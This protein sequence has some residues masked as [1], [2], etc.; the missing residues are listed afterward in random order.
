MRGG[1]Q[2]G[3]QHMQAHHQH[4]IVANSTLCMSL[5]R[6]GD[7]LVWQANNSSDIS[8]CLRQSP[9]IVVDS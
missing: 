2:Q 3:L 9:L 4:W 8:Y 6:E 7:H 1:L 5:Q